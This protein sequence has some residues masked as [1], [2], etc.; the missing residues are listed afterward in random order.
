MAGALQAIEP[1]GGHVANGKHPMRRASVTLVPLIAVL[2]TPPARPDT[3]PAVGR[4]DGLLR[5]WF[6]LSTKDLRALSHRR[7]VVRSLD[8]VDDREIATVGIV[9]MRVPP[10]FFADRLRD[11]ESRGG[12]L[13]LETAAFS[14]P[15][16]ADDLRTLSFEPDFIRDLG[17]CRV[18]D[19]QVQLS[20]EAIAR[21]SRL[22][23]D[24]PEAATADTMRA[25]LA[26]MMR[27][28]QQRGAAALMTYADDHED[29][30]VAAEFGRMV[31]DPPALLQRLPALR[32]HLAR[33]PHGGGDGVRDVLYW[34]KDRIGP[35]VI[36]SATHLAIA[37]SDGDAIAAAAVSRQ[38]YASRYFEASVGITLVLDH[39]EESG[40]VCDVVYV[41]RS[42]V[43]VFGGIFGGLKRLIARHRVR[44][45]MAHAILRV[46]DRLEMD[47]AR[48]SDARTAR[49]H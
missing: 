47:F 8:T 4:A 46:R 2:G 35:A 6:A 49:S 33:F 27:G 14:T 13:V 5:E 26:D 12:D 15:P 20:R 28:Y 48:R 9:R 24:T 21:I 40:P 32:D 7:A 25:I 10:S 38:L 45:G 37:G 39:V 11:I 19:C 43:D 22:P 36:V 31:S 3:K 34:S 18:H 42:R 1:G 30:S 41:N 29:H 16:R 23:E 44:D 17:R